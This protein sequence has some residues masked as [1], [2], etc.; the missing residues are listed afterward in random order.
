MKRRCIRCGGKMRFAGIGGFAWV[1][2]VRNYKCTQCD[3]TEW[4]MCR[5]KRA[6]KDGRD[7]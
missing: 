4:V 6:G 5:D 1:F 7:G 3:Y 2:R